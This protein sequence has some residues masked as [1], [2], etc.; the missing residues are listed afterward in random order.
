MELGYHYASRFKEKWKGI[1]LQNCWRFNSV[2]LMQRHIIEFKANQADAFSTSFLH[3]FPTSFSAFGND[4]I[5]LQ[6]K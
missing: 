1:I 2:F 5:T 6:K 4:S 3:Y